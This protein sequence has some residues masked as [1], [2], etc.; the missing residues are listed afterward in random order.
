MSKSN[1]RRDQ[2]EDEGQDKLEFDLSM[3]DDD[4]VLS[5]ADEIPDEFLVTTDE[6]EKIDTRTGE[7]V[8]T[9]EELVSN[10]SEDDDWAGVDDS[11]F[12]PD[13]DD[14][15]GEDSD[16]EDE[17]EETKEVEV[18]PKKTDQDLILTRLIKA[19]KHGSVKGLCDF[20]RKY[21]E[22]DYDSRFKP[23]VSRV[24]EI[25]QKYRTGG[26]QQNLGDIPDDLL[27]LGALMVSLSEPLG[28]LEGAFEDV[29][30]CRKLALAGFYMELKRAEEELGISITNKDAEHASRVLARDYIKDKGEASILMRQLRNLWYGLRHLIDILDGSLRRAGSE[31]KRMEQAE[32]VVHKSPQ[33]QSSVPDDDEE[34]DDEEGITGEWNG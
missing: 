8:D 16:E 5:N 26:I 9:L 10:E 17:P 25:T 22:I 4:E 29:D 13:L 24:H 30:E 6:G 27:E 11:Q 2:G 15:D 32:G 7:I 18:E 31:F 28:F 21:G 20:S 34:W 14:L 23:I 33:T 3:F 1:K 19:A 12:E